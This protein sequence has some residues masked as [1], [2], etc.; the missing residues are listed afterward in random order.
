M[1]QVEKIV[2][3][4]INSS[5]GT[6]PLTLGKTQF[7]VKWVGYDSSQNTWEPEKHLCT[8]KNLIQKFYQSQGKK[9]NGKNSPNSKNSSPLEDSLHNDEADEKSDDDGSLGSFGNDY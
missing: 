1:Y 9:D 8:V 2:A 3:S 4:R 6:P 7:L 5:T